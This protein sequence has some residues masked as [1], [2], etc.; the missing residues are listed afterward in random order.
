MIALQQM[1]LQA[2]GDQIR[3]LP[4]WP[5]DWNV[6]FKLHAPN[7]TTITATHCDGRLVRLRKDIMH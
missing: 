6:D 3:L 7:K 5:A 1:L 4:A 2:D